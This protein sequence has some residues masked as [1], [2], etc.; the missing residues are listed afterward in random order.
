MDKEF[1][2]AVDS[3]TQ[4]IRAI[5]YD[6]SGSE[7]AKSQLDLDPYFSVNPGWAEQSPDDYWTKFCRV[8]K[9]VMTHKD[10]DP[11]KVC[12]LGITTQR[13]C[14]IPMNRDG[15]PLRNCIIWLDQ[16]FTDDPP[17]VDWKI[18]SF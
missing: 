14:I 9:E 5:V 6:R 1:V 17:P 8:V 16:R 12:G 2:I 11:K 13:G 4:S 7:I 3:G 10:V 18:K 15:T